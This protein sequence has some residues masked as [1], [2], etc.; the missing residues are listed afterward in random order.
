MTNISTAEGASR[1]SVVQGAAWAVPAIAVGAP[2]MALTASHPHCETSDVVIAVDSSINP[3]TEGRVYLDPYKPAQYLY[4]GSSNPVVDPEQRTEFT[5]PKTVDTWRTTDAY[6]TNNWL[7]FNRADVPSGNGPQHVL[8]S[9]STQS[10]TKPEIAPYFDFKYTLTVNQDITD[11]TIL[12]YG[13]GP[14]DTIARKTNG[15]AFNPR[16]VPMYV[17]RSVSYTAPAG[18]KDLAATL[19][20]L[21]GVALYATNSAGSDIS[22]LTLSPNLPTVAADAAGFDNFAHGAQPSSTAIGASEANL[23]ANSSVYYS[24]LDSDVKQSTMRISPQR[25][26][27]MLN[28]KDG[29]YWMYPG[30]FGWKVNGTIPAGT[31]LTFQFRYHAVT[32]RTNIVKYQRYVENGKNVDRE[33]TGGWVNYNVNFAWKRASGGNAYGAVANNEVTETPCIHPLRVW[34]NHAPGANPQAPGGEDNWEWGI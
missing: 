13:N 19:S 6:N 11:L 16:H 27:K 14:D 26:Y 9:A 22:G 32:L 20:G 24:A 12:G 25:Q 31:A 3:P 5:L 21:K 1:R 7:F 23:G 33:Y 30:T 4:N 34:I 10:A 8:I 17:D 29:V 28:D 15:V 18:A 2:A